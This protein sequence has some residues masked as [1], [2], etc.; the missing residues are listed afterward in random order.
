[1]P[2]SDRTCNGQDAVIEDLCAFS[3]ILSNL[4]PETY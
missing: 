4:D 3:Q 1:M 2:Y